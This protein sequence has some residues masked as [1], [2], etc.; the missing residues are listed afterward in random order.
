MRKEVPRLLHNAKSRPVYS[1]KAVF[2]DEQIL[3]SYIPKKNK[4]IFLLSSIHN[5]M[6]ISKLPKKKP[7]IILDYNRGKG[8][9]DKLDQE[10]KEY[11][12]YRTTNR[13]PCLIFYDLIGFVCIAC[14]VLY[15]IKFPDSPIV[16]QNKRK[17]FLYILSKQLCKPIILERQI[18]PGFKLCSKMI[19]RA[20]AIILEQCTS[21]PVITD[22][23][24]DLSDVLSSHTETPETMMIPPLVEDQV[25]SSPISL[26]PKVISDQTPKS[27]P[28]TKRGRCQECSRNSDKKFGQ[29]CYFCDHVI[30]PEHSQTFRICITCRREMQ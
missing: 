2:S 12:F 9:V 22:S 29:S 15:C 25:S 17:E 5:D 30:C 13:W 23:S 20:S 8:G 4:N 16:R 28:K 21:L 19:K 27:K 14:W 18:S 7:N 6:K 26:I 3:L 24:E 1:S 10:I 11:R